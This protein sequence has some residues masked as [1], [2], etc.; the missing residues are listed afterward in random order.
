[1]WKQWDVNVGNNVM[2]KAMMQW[3]RQLERQWGSKGITEVAK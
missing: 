1:V 2:N 3:A